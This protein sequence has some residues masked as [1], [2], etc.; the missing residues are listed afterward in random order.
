MGDCGEKVL[1]GDSMGLQVRNRGVGK[2]SDVP[3]FGQRVRQIDPP[4]LPGPDRRRGVQALRVAFN[5]FE[6]DVL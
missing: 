3:G 5:P 2:G 1:E 6:V 4:L